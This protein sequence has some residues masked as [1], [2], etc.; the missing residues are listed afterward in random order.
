MKANQLVTNELDDPK[1]YDEISTTL[2]RKKFLRSFYLEVYQRYASILAR[3]PKDGIALELGSG[4]GF[5]K[6]ILPEVIT[7]DVIDYQGVDRKLDARALPFENESLRAILMFDVFHHIP[8]VEKF[9]FE[10]Q[11]CLKP[12]GR[13]FIVDSYLGWISTPIFKFFHHEP[14]VPEAS[15]W[16]FDSKGPLSDSN[17][18]LSWIV[19]KRD[20]AKFEA[21]YPQLKIEG[22]VPHSPLRYWM[23][24]GMKSWSLVPGSCFGIMSK[25]DSL[26]IRATPKFASFVD[27]EIVKLW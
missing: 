23:S 3:C 10:A 15:S 26:L 22:T 18:A 12:G 8:D 13:I 25:I 4:A 24:G 21:L 5:V 27:I 14:F 1:R 2:R 11:R 9:L 20:R 17:T 7:S 19:F 16:K 6:E